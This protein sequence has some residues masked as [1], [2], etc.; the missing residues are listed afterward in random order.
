MVMI[1]SVFPLFLFLTAVSGC[2][3]WQQDSG[4][5]PHKRVFEND[6]AL[7]RA[8]HG[9]TVTCDLQDCP[10]FL[11]GL[12]IIDFSEGE[13]RGL[14]SCSGTLIGNNRIL[15]NA[16]CIPKDLQKA[17]ASCHGRIK[18]NLPQTAQ[19]K[20]ERWDC[21]RVVDVSVDTE[22][23]I[24]PDYAII[25]MTGVTSRDPVV[26]R[27]EGILANAPVTLYKVDFDLYASRLSKGR[28]VKTACRANA[29]YFLSKQFTGPKSALMN[30]S[31]CSQK[32]R[33]G[34]SG[35]GILNGDNELIALFSF[36]VFVEDSDE[37]W[38]MA[39][40]EEHPLIKQ[41][42]GGG[43]NLACVPEMGRFAEDFRCH[44]GGSDHYE[45]L[46]RVAHFLRAM[47]ADKLSRPGFI[48][49]SWRFV[50][51]QPATLQPG[52]PSSYVQWAPVNRVRMEDS[53]VEEPP[54]AQ[55]SVLEQSASK[56]SAA[57]EQVQELYHKAIRV[58]FPH[59]PVCVR[60][61]APLK[62]QTSF[63]QLRFNGPHVSSDFVEYRENYSVSRGVEFRKISPQLYKMELAGDGFWGFLKVYL[64]DGLT[65]KR[66]H[67]VRVCDS[68]L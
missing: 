9:S 4:P 49:E 24:E 28:V 51:E 26:V 13:K 44:F 8:F 48:A 56:Q 52:V 45:S 19:F 10:S 61:S 47:E 43:T 37:P 30:V 39:I 46:S 58:R 62:F 38:A 42:A 14:Y 27:G 54:M 29:E 2:S 5:D 41:N 53:I 20:M 57:E 32:L 64:D 18:I 7:T 6:G 25:E 22:S 1:K 16:H 60:P 40:R 55:Q 15:T 34:N 67:L 36:G 31:Y 23:S 63:M 12:Y 66:S 33:E 17:G 35:A 21:S 65:K 59:W 68:S 11:A 50:K 3:R